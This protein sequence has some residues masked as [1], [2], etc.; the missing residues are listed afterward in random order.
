[1]RSFA[2]LALALLP[3]WVVPR[4]AFAAS[5]LGGSCDLS[6]LGVRDEAGFRRFDQALRE[7]V[8]ARDAQALSALVDYPVRANYGS[9]GHVE[10]R[11]AA[12]LLGARLDDLWPT[13]QE[14]VMGHPAATLFCNDQGVMYGNGA[15]WANPEGADGLFRITA[16]NFPGPAPAH[17]PLA[18]AVRVSLSPQAAARLRAAHEAITADA[19]YYG[20]PT[21]Q[22]RKHADE[23]GQIDLGDER[24]EVP[25]RA[26][27]VRFTGR[28]VDRARLGWITGGV[29][30][31]VN[32]WSSRHSSPDNLLGCDFIDGSLATVIRAQ[33]VVL[34]CGLITEHP[35]TRMKP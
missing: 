29:K 3:V 25:G 23:A 9:G 16:F 35:D 12:A 33:P 8:R 32:L 31:N 15:V 1:M 21:A 4:W 17:E 24:I 11:D 6:V 5:R 18:F 22:G 10:L 28:A 14:A 13:L 7:A 27:I 19:R 2:I 30:V 26:G 34:R 20:D